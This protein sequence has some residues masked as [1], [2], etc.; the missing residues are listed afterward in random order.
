VTEYRPDS[1]LRAAGL[2]K[3]FAGRTVLKNLD[4]VVRP[5]EVHGLVGQNGSGKS[6]FIKILAGYHEPDDGGAL[7][8]CDREISLPVSPGES[9]R[10]GMS[11]VHQDLG[12]IED[13][14][15]LENVRIGRYRTGIGWSVSWRKESDRVRRMLE[16][17]GIDVSPSAIIADLPP[18]DCAMVA[19][20]RA[21]DQVREQEDHDEIGTP[22][23]V[24]D[25]PTPH[26]P[27]DGVERLF[28]AVREVAAAGVGILFVTHR[29]D[30]VLEL[31]DRVTVMRDGGR[32]GVYET[33]SL[34]EGKLV[35]AILGFSLE[36]LYPTPGHVQGERALRIGGLSGPGVHEFNL[37]AARGEIV[38]LTG[39]I[40][41]GWDSV[42]YLL[43]GSAAPES[44]T[45]IL[46][47]RTSDLSKR[48]PRKAIS[49]HFAL[50]PADRRHSG[51]LLEASVAENVTLATLG[52]YFSN[53]FL[54]PKREMRRVRELLDEFDVRPREPQ[55]ELSTFSGG[56]Q[57]K[58]VIAKWFET[59]P[60]VLLLHE[61]TQ[62][63]DVG[64]RA[65]IFERVRDAA[66]EGMIVLYA[67]A[68]WED[69][70]HLCTRVLVFRD[71]RVA[72]E[73]SGAELTAGRIAEQSFSGLSALAQDAG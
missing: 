54:R 60:E 20:A 49:D 12:L 28:S 61:P 24:L 5:G 73:I 6:T 70:A 32:V 17:F 45:C 23:L 65:Q 21:L 56:N 18:V 64:A 52:G 50:V 22:L 31:T 72:S 35:E 1:V 53:G 47:G 26:L 46:N 48:T 30:E 29:L 59:R 16:R 19:I 44:G 7:S 27:R 62:G 13:A 66:E 25:E 38:G 57:Q 42:P 15:V 9:R 3:T 11:F 4:L 68:E 8:V 43:F 63:V 33:S 2:S 51:A 10:L 58:A 67:S 69:L 37:E 55:R 39:L 34:T 41:M 14:S 40:G 71:G 36:R